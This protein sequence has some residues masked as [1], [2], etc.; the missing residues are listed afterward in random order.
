M[1][2]AMVVAGP[3]PSPQ[4]SQIFAGQMA[5][6][7]GRRGH[8]VHL[9][10]YGQGK[11]VDDCHFVHHRLHRVPGDASLRSGPRI[12]KPLL[13]G[14]MVHALIR[15]IRRHRIEVVQAHNYEAALIGLA[16]RFRTGAPVVYH[17]HNLMGDELST[18]FD[19]AAFKRGADAL[20]R[21]LDCTVPR[22][23]DHVIALCDYSA[24]ALLA[25]GVEAEKLSVIPAA[26]SD[27]VVWEDRRRAKRALG[28][29]VDTSVVGYCGNLDG[30]QNLPLLFDAARE[31]AQNET[32]GQI[33]FVVVTHLSQRGIDRMK[34]R[35]AIPDSVAVLSLPSF[36]QAKRVIE[37][38]DVV[39]LPRRRGSGY[40]I[41]LLNYMS[42]GR[43]V[44]TAGCG[45]KIIRDGD[46]GLVVDDDDPHCMAE[47][48]R[49]LT[50]DRGLRQRL[51]ACARRRF[52][53]EMTW[54]T[55]LPAVEAAVAGV[56]ARQLTRAETEPRTWRERRKGL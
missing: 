1:R 37:A 56:R 34:I 16:A 32:Q 26:I 14:L 33:A 38:S 27:D 45:A 41:K 15:L 44:V 4:G 9:L 29:D 36:Q 3:L 49:R 52:E 18:Y 25:A 21:R 31:I 51:A 2:V 5:D 46:D 40:P 24:E 20:G 8:E 6:Q 28:I 12:I 11:R 30:Y 17:S 39:V 48:I 55:V 10:T 53:R 47:A 50:G 22:R 13:D 35:M 43:A 23:A 19:A 7:M 42:A 54:K